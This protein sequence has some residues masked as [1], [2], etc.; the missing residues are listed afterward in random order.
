MA[1]HR[2]VDLVELQLNDFEQ[3]VVEQLIENNDLVETVDE[4]GIERLPH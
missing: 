1:V 3:L 2:L 4:L